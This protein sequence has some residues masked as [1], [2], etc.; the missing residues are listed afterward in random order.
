M[1]NIPLQAGRVAAMLL[2]CLSAAWGGQHTRRISAQVPQSAART[3]ME[4][5]TPNTLV[6]R[7]VYNE[8]NAHDGGNYM[9]RDWRQ[10]PS[11]SKTKEMIET[12]DGVV[13]RLIAINNHPLTPTERSAE[14]ARLQDLLNHPQLQLEK[15]KEQEQ[16]E[17]RV[18]RMFKELPNAFIYQYDGVQPSNWGELIRLSFSPDPNFRSPSRETSVFRAMSGHMWISASDQRLARIEASLFRDVTFG[19]GI[20]GHLDKGGHFIVQQSKIAPGRWEATDMNIQFTGKAL[21]F[22]TINL[23]QIERL[24]DFHR[25]PDGL[26]LAQGIELLNKNGNQMAENS[27]G[28]GR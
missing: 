4:S 26:S 3:L 9:Y 15:K 13:A 27:G 23:R 28:G 5:V 25:V 8:L 2:L 19:W 18:K 17:A 24:N 20:L 14:N 10:T 1:S 16:D 7:V 11:G 21:F 12:R 6:K 22:K